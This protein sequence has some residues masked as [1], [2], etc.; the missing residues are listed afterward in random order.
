[1]HDAE[2]VGVAEGIGDFTRNQ[3]G[4]VDGQLLLALE[5]LAQNVLARQ[6]TDIDTTGPKRSDRE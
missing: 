5:A 4:D 2:A 3:E 6:G 1:M